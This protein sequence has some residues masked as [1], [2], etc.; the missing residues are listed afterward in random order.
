MKK[1]QLFAV[2]AILLIAQI[3][4]AQQIIYGDKNK[5][6]AS[7]ISNNEIMH[8]ATKT[9]YVVDETVPNTFTTGNNTLIICQLVPGSDTNI[10]CSTSM[11]ENGWGTMVSQENEKYTYQEKSYSDGTD[12]YSIVF[13][14]PNNGWA[15][16]VMESL[17]TQSGVVFHTKDGGKSWILQYLGGT[18]ISLNS[19]GFIDPKKGRAYGERTVG[20]TTFEICLTTADGGETWTEQSLA[21]LN[22]N[23][24]SSQ[25]Y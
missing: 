25:L 18:G 21:Q 5:N 20:N 17:S 4:I 22:G 13:T 11:P 14:D 15:V 12:I 9:Y 16:G 8:P 1:K 19:V 6:N 10:L 3:T 24:I 2:F 7:L 23:H